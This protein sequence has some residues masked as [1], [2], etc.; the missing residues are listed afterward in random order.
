MLIS[1]LQDFSSCEEIFYKTGFNYTVVDT[2]KM[3]DDKLAALIEKGMKTKTVSRESIMEIL[4]QK[5]IKDYR[6]GLHIEN[7]TVYFVDIEHRKNI[8]RIFPY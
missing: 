6:I 5:W 8:Y 3:E 2:E 7:E 1:S 4:K